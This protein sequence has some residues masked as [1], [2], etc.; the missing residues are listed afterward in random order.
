MLHVPLYVQMC[1]V[2]LRPL[3]ALLLMF[4][5]TVSDEAEP[6]P[7]PAAAAAN[8][9]ARDGND[10][11]VRAKASNNAGLVVMTGCVAEPSSRLSI[12]RTRPK[13]SKCCGCRLYG[14]NAAVS[15]KA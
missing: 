2:Y 7:A 14:S 6:K 12:T 5:L 9:A 1:T 3:D 15:P 10:G 13:T 4:W 8:R 11:I